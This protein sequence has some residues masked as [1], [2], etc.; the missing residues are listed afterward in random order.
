MHV[1][2]CVMV[3]LTR[4][5]AARLEQAGVGEGET[6]AFV[7]REQVGCKQIAVWEK[8]GGV[9]AYT[10]TPR[11]KTER[12]QVDHVLEIQI[13]EIAFAHAFSEC[14]GASARSIDTAIANSVLKDVFNDISNLN[15]TSARVNQSKKGPFTAAI[16][17]LKNPTLRKVSLE[18]LA[19]SGNARWLV[20]NGDWGRIEK[21]IVVSWDAACEQLNERRPSAAAGR[22]VD[23]QVDELSSVLDG[24]G[25]Q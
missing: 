19:R 5:A 7:L 24:L 9:D 10:S 8:R 16:N 1:V 18:Q 17:R 3:V 22:L 11:S 2:G 14:R 13:A 15:V 6:S 20:E 21:E 4:S 23:S 25:L 12:P